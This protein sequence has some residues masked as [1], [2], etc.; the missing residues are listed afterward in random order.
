MKSIR[1]QFVPC[2]GVGAL[3]AAGLLGATSN[4]Q[5]PAVRH[6]GLMSQM[7]T[8]LAMTPTQRDQARAA[9][10][11]ARQSARR[12]RQQLRETSKSLQAAIRSDD[13][14]Q[15]KQL[16]T[17]EGQEIGQLMAIRSVAFATVYNTLTPDQKE[18]ADALRRI[19]AR[20][21]RRQTQQVGTHASS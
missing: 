4:V 3:T 1:K 8:V 21:F 12:I 17:T 11:Q 18:R 7:E 6:Q 5:K 2:I 20:R 10:D 9:F 19:M 13:T 14:A 16:S 15:I